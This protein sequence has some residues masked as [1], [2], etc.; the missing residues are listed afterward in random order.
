MVEMTTTMKMKSG[1]RRFLKLTIGAELRHPDAEPQ[2][3]TRSE[4]RHSI[5]SETRSNAVREGAEPLNWWRRQG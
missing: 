3:V 5:V 1:T 2:A 4:P